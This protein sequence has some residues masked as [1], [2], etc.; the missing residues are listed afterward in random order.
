MDLLQ[1]TCK[2]KNLAN[3]IS[4]TTCQMYYSYRL[5]QSRLVSTQWLWAIRTLLLVG[6]LVTPRGY[7]SKLLI[8]GKTVVKSR[9]VERFFKPR[10]L[11]RAS[12]MC[13]YF[14][15]IFF[16]YVDLYKSSVYGSMCT[17]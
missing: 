15:L 6:L 16:F 9:H 4:H 2:H 8:I 17:S 11:H 12:L 14:Y 7:S 1:S 10:C 13:T 3:I 5:S